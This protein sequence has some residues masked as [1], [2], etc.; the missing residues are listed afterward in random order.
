MGTTK[1]DKAEVDD[2]D[3]EQIARLITEG[4]T[5]G[6]SDNEGY[7]ISWSIRIYKFKN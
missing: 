4:Y 6:I 7:R 3:L 1:E 5:S 2:F